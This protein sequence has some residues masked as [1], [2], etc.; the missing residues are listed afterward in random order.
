MEQSFEDF[1]KTNRDLSL[2]RPHR[3]KKS[4][5][6]INGLTYYRRVR[7]KDLDF[8]IDQC[9][10]LSIIREMNLLMVDRLV[11][12]KS[13]TLPSG[14]GKLEIVK[15]ESASWIDKN[16]K[17]GTNRPVNYLETNRLWYE[18]EEA[19][20]NKTLVRYDTD[21]TFRLKYKMRGR[22]YKNCR[23]FSIQF[24]RH[25]KSRLTEEIRKGGYDA[26]KLKT[27]YNE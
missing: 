27:Y 22:L 24:G 17:L 20:L 6:T 5:H 4:Y 13:F 19:R 18:D 26:Y 3:I 8:I 15:M 7:P 12:N 2:P 9:Q 25:I 21:A 1:L 10:Y 14:M 23:Y 16:G 11:V